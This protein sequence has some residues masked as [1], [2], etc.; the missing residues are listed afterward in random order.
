MNLKE[1]K[2]GI[3]IDRNNIDRELCMQAACF[4]AA[5]EMALEAEQNYKLKEIRHNEFLAIKDEEI[6]NAFGPKKPTVAEMEA[7]M[8]RDKDVMTAKL[9]MLRF[10]TQRRLIGIIRDGWKSRKDMLIQTAIDLR[11]ERENLNPFVK[12]KGGME[13]EQMAA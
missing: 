10:D 6:R 4:V 13:R 3:P 8:N 12:S 9:E 11:S 2:V 1:L 5:S 7:A